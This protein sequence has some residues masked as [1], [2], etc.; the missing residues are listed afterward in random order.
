M[1][2]K[3]SD[4]VKEKIER[5]ATKYPSRRAAVKS[6]LRYAQQEFGWVSEDVIKAVSEVLGL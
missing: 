2:Y 6:A 5:E 3:L 4:S 1:P